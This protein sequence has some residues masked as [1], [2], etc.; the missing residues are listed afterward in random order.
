MSVA[1]QF[2]RRQFLTTLAA[3]SGAAVLAG[4]AVPAAPAQDDGGSAP[5]DEAVVL[6]VDTRTSEVPFME[7]TF[8]WFK[9]DHPN[10]DHEIHGTPDNFQETFIDDGDVDM[11]EALRVFREVGYDGPLVPDHFP[12]ITVDD[13]RWGTVGYALGYMKA[14]VRG[15]EETGPS[16]APIQ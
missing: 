8:A 15:V 7:E 9:E 1:T 2:T 16:T 6:T 12:R 14:L 13:S 5:S 4:C 3:A 11:L 10:T